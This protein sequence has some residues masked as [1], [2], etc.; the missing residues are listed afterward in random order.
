MTAGMADSTED[1]S[2]KVTL[3]RTQDVPLFVAGALRLEKW[4]EMGM[5]W[6]VIS[7]RLMRLLRLLRGLLGGSCWL[8][9][10]LLRLDKV[11]EED[12]MTRFDHQVM[13]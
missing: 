3:T 4:E 10:I 5:G 11:I 8:R 13:K 7:A 1:G 9:R 2:W 12:E 6:L